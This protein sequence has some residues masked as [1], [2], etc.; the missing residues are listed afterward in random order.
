M[1][2]LLNHQDPSVTFQLHK[3]VRPSTLAELAS[4]PSGSEEAASAPTRASSASLRATQHLVCDMAQLLS[5]DPWPD[6]RDDPLRS[7][8]LLAEDSNP[9]QTAAAELVTADELAG[10]AVDQPVSSE[11]AIPPLQLAEPVIADEDDH[12]DEN[13][14][15]LGSDSSSDGPT[16]AAGSAS[17][18]PA[19]R[20]VRS[21]ARK[22]NVV[23]DDGERLSDIRLCVSQ[24]GAAASTWYEF[25]LHAGVLRARCPALAELLS[26]AQS[27]SAMSSAGGSGVQPQLLMLEPGQA[28]ASV[29]MVRAAVQFLYTDTLCMPPASDIPD[30]VLRMCGIDAASFGTEELIRDATEVGCIED[31]GESAVVVSE[32]TSLLRAG[33]RIIR[34]DV[35]FTEYFRDLG[36]VPVVGSTDVG[37]RVGERAKEDDEQA[38]AIA[39][40]VAADSSLLP[41]AHGGPRHS[42]TMGPKLLGPDPRLRHWLA[43]LHECFK[44]A[45]MFRLPRLADLAA[46][47]AARALSMHSARPLAELAAVHQREDLWRAAVQWCASALPIL[48]AVGEP[49]FAACDSS[50]SAA[51]I[52]RA[53]VG[54]GPDCEPAMLRVD[55]ESPVVKAQEDGGTVDEELDAVQKTVSLIT[56]PPTTVTDFSSALAQDATRLARLQRVRVPFD[57]QRMTQAKLMAGASDGILS[58]R[59]R[60]H[61]YLA[62][63]D[64]ALFCEATGLVNPIA[65]EQQAGQSE[66]PPSESSAAQA[67]AAAGAASIPTVMDIFTDDD[68]DGGVDG[69]DDEDADD[70]EDAGSEGDDDSYNDFSSEADDDEEMG[71]Q[72]GQAVNAVV[73]DRREDP[74]VGEILGI[75]ESRVMETNAMVGER[76]LSARRADL[77]HAMSSWRVADRAFSSSSVGE[78]DDDDDD[79]EADDED[80]EANAPGENGLSPPPATSP[81]PPAPP[82][83]ASHNLEQHRHLSSLLQLLPDHPESHELRALVELMRRSMRDM[84]PDE[85]SHHRAKRPKA[86]GEPLEPTIPLPDLLAP[87]PTVYRRLVRDALQAWSIIES[88]NEG[89][90]D[91]IDA[92][93]SQ[94]SIQVVAQALQLEG[95]LR[96]KF[97]GVWA[98]LPP[99]DAQHA[100]IRA[101]L[102]NYGRV[103]RRQ[104]GVRERPVAVAAVEAATAAA[105]SAIA[106]VPP[107]PVASLVPQSVAAPAG[108]AKDSAVQ[109]HPIEG[110]V[111]LHIA[112]CGNA[113]RRS[114]HVEVAVERVARLR[115]PLKSML[116][117]L[118]S[119]MAAGI[120]L[121]GA[122]GAVEAILEWSSHPIPEVHVRT[123]DVRLQGQGHSPATVSQI[124]DLARRAALF[125]ALLE[126]ATQ[127]GAASRNESSAVAVP[128]PSEVSV[129]SRMAVKPDAEKRPAVSWHPRVM[130]LLRYIPPV[131]TSH[132]VPC[133]PGGRLFPILGGENRVQY[134]TYGPTLTLD[135]ATNQWQR[136]PATGSF[137][138]NMIR[139]SSAAIHV[140][141]PFSPWS[142]A[143]SGVV[144]DLQ[145]LWPEKRGNS[146]LAAGL[147]PPIDGEDG[148]DGIA[149]VLRLRGAAWGQPRF[150]FTLGDN[151]LR[152]KGSLNCDV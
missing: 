137:P 109:A 99:L 48:R 16:P 61:A 28:R 47:R 74:F 20:L 106:M 72:L 45:R 67:A 147:P 128:A 71:T 96:R 73:G 60:N 25:R 4:D 49:G 89:V 34:A 6:P 77:G 102:T 85:G 36:D 52:Q 125:V 86:K 136:L 65:R 111:L 90:L 43:S 57:L 84:G 42:R 148:L 110:F 100:R 2:A 122:S 14:D 29:A 12:D 149:P 30:A 32:A 126:S 81:S 75:C 142:C 46:W 35:S 138:S 93:S 94:A 135:M 33:G 115:L 131:S 26:S 108:V 54:L 146:T 117:W 103:G 97:A 50:S 68:D 152:R 123:S 143:P 140:P 107:P 127:A 141:S 27:A 80:D 21:Y 70:I 95:D 22:R 24:P 114:S 62:I 64:E 118:R 18:A 151:S 134:I 41:R 51:A 5:S 11:S 38:A 59:M 83:R 78:A 39:A 132:T 31:L 23:G 119:R 139:A 53:N 7:V 101:V 130:Q 91:V 145:A 10:S 133:G 124:V 116:R 13:E 150:V 9:E 66:L 144:A 98:S 44:A 104:R 112:H 58:G 88:R 63:R 113:G 69:D 56:L 105:P 82:S 15:D 55:R 121:S 129:H 87:V 92:L 40:S 8:T 1:I 76:S 17:P 120:P 3:L 37:A 79:N 19:L